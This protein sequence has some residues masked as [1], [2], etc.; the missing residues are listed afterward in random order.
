MKFEK[1]IIDNLDHCYSCANIEI[2]G[3]N[4]FLTASEERNSC[5]MIDEESGKIVS[6][7]D[8][9]GGTMSIVP[10]EGRNGEFLA[11]QRFY[12]GFNASESTIVWAAL[13]D[14]EWLVKTLFTLPYIHRFD[15]L[16]SDNGK[17]YFI[18]CTLCETKETLEDWSSGGHIVVSILPNDLEEPFELESILSNLVRNH[19]YYK[20]KANGLDACIVTCDSGGYL[21]EPPNISNERWKITQILNWS[22]SD[23]AVFD[24]DGDG[25][26]EI[27]TIEPFHGNSF[28][29]YKKINNNYEKVYEY[30]GK[31]EFG[32][33]VW[34]GTLVGVPTIIGGYRGLSKELFYIQYI[35]GEYRTETIDEG[36]GPCNIFVVHHE[37]TDVIVATNG[38]VNQIVKYTVSK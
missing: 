24:I 9:I 31:M 32:H 35:D 2:D 17:K 28:Y 29:I 34:G 22:I 4:H 15:V 6:V 11:S 3:K 27:V 20:T 38:A 14:G 19:G 5:H 1:E 18:G 36:V 30:P 7:W 26:E 37:T 13:K 8:N 33:V 23:L 16:E 12:P 21:I 10:L 25:N